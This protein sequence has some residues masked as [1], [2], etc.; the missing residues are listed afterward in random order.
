MSSAGRSRPSNAL[1]VPAWPRRFDEERAIELARS[2]GRD[3]VCFNRIGRWAWWQ[4]RDA[5]GGR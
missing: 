4:G 1:T 5:G 2:A 3:T